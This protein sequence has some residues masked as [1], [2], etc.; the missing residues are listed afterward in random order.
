MEELR[1]RLQPRLLPQYT[2]HKPTPKQAAFLLLP[3][4]EAFYG[5][6]AG[7]GKSDALLMAALQYVDQ[8]NYS[9]ILFRRTFQ[10]LALPGALLERSHDWLNGTDAVFKEKDHRWYF[11]SGATL[12]FGYMEHEKDKYRYQSSEFQFVG[13]DELTQFSETQY[14]YLFSRLRRLETSQIPIRMRG[15]A[16]PGGVGH[17]WVRQ[18]FVVE[19]KTQGRIFIPAGLRDNPYLDQE[20]YR[21]SL[22]N[23]DTLERAQLLD[24]DWSAKQ[25]G[26]LFDRSW[27]VD[28]IVDRVPEGVAVL[29]RVRYWDLAATDNVDSNYTVGVLM[30]LGDDGN[31][32]L[33][34]ITRFK[35]TP[36]VVE[37]RVA[38]TAV[39]DGKLRTVIWMEQEPGSGGVN[40]I[41]HYRRRVLRGF[42]FKPDKPTT[43]KTNRARP[44]S[45]AC[46][47]GLVY[48][49]RGTWINTFLDELEAFP[50]TEDKDQTDSAAAAFVRVSSRTIAGSRGSRRRA[51]S[52]IWS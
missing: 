34:D 24:G 43:N 30:A 51:A 23:L 52:G 12:S 15:A 26:S 40:T 17:E 31:F 18:R 45:A 8:P 36:Q 9:A 44:F 27:F 11:P 5:G 41:D 21:N 42:V 10:D 2:P 16:N 47:G 6:A 50:N 7:G 3:N 20:T 25:A 48:L 1:K 29:R 38:A 19:G 13:F 37:R 32:Y 33:L 28:R 49:C 46:E 39:R 35:G 4:E 14:R 22:M